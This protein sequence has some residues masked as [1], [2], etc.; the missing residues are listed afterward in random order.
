MITCMTGLH[1]SWQCTTNKQHPTSSHNAHGRLKTHLSLLAASN[2]STIYWPELVRVNVCQR[3]KCGTSGRESLGETQTVFGQ[4]IR[5]SSDTFTKDLAISV[6][7][8][9]QN[10]F[11]VALCSIFSHGFW[12]LSKLFSL[13]L[14]VYWTRLR[15]VSVVYLALD[16]L[17][18]VSSVFKVYFFIL[19]LSLY[20]T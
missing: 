9:W 15:H 18:S 1:Q 2:I 14:S 16:L 13:C 7:Q 3:N 12:P 20:Q 6:W 11:I 5:T 17:F 19:N 4:S 8:S 10:W